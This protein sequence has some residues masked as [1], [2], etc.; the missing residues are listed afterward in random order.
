[1]FSD[2]IK[3]SELEHAILACTETLGVLRTT[4]EKH[5]FKD[6]AH[7]I[8]FFKNIKPR[9]VGY[10]NYFMNLIDIQRGRPLAGEK[11]ERK[12]FT[13]QITLL[14]NYFRENQELYE[15]YLRD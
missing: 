15:Y 3:Y 11:L 14:Q 2:P 4:V 6:S 13:E 7:E 5:G 10:M 1:K 9:I 8:E 12:F